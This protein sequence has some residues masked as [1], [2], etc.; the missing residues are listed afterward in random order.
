MLLFPPSLSPEQESP[1]EFALQFWDDAKLKNASLVVGIIGTMV[2]TADSEDALL[3]I[4]IQKAPEHIR[5]LMELGI[6]SNAPPSLKAQALG[7]LAGYNQAPPL[8][9]TVIP[10][11]PVPNTNGEEWDRL[12]PCRALDLLVSTVLDGEYG[13]LGVTAPTGKE[14]MEFRGVALSTFDVSGPLRLS[15]FIS[16]PRM[17]ELCQRRRGCN[18]H[19]ERNAPNISTTTSSEFR[20]RSAAHQHIHF[21]QLP[22]IPPG[23]CE[24]AV[25]VPLVFLTLPRPAQSLEYVPKGHCSRT[26]GYTDCFGG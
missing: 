26:R 6:A 16:S 3:L 20:I 21:T 9:Q 4:S 1:Q 17:L 23:G 14:S 25:H 2:R 7:L 13:G 18:R 22:T 8:F 19:L 24:A 5:L 15:P 10:Y 11:H 12:D